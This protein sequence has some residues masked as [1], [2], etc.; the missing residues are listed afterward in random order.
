MNNQQIINK[1]CP[2]G[3][4]L[5][6]GTEE[7]AHIEGVDLDRLTHCDPCIKSAIGD[8]RYHDWRDDG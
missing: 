1:I 2:C 6:Q 4:P 7:D 5:Y 8:A 3:T